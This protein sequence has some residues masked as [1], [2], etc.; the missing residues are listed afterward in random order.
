[1]MTLYLFILYIL[2]FLSILITVLLMVAF[3]TVYERK[4]IASTQR[5]AG[6]SNIGPF[7]MLQAVADGLKLLL[8]SGPKPSFSNKFFFVIC[9]L[10]TFFFKFIIMGSYTFRI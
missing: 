10:A 7:G 1:M 8:K 3:Y 2:K 4:I 6:P 9:P 5:R